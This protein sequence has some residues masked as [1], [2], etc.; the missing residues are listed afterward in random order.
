MLARFPMLVALLVGGA[1]ILSQSWL[2]HAPNIK[3]T[4]AALL[5]SAYFF[6]SR[7]CRALV[8]ALVLLGWSQGLEGGSTWLTWAVLISFGWPLLSGRLLRAFV[9]RRNAP[10]AA[11][12]MAWS[13]VA[14]LGAAVGFWLTT[15]LAFWLW[16]GVYAH[17][18]AGFAECFWMSLPFF[19][20]SVAGDLAFA[21]A[22]FGTLEA[23]HAA[24]AQRC[25]ELPGETSVPRFGQHAHPTCL[26]GGLPGP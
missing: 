1:A 19:R 15:N 20:L 25:Q 24:A 26:A 18:L 3:M 7:L 13:L 12:R 9:T 10:G 22:L 21:A 23:L 4:S 16:G 6:P 11:G 8:V 5:F 2:A 14:A 17:S